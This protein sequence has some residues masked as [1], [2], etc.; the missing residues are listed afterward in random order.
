VFAILLLPPLL[1]LLP[2]LL[3]LLLLLLF[4]S[5]L[6]LP[7]LQVNLAQRTAGSLGRSNLSPG[8]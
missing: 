6:L 5:A 8:G 1:L 4:S 3:L 7:G 2:P